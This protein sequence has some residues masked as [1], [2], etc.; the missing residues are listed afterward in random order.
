MVGKLLGSSLFGFALD[1]YFSSTLTKVSPWF[2]GMKQAPQI[3]SKKLAEAKMRNMYPI[4]RLA[5]RVG[6]ILTTAALMHMVRAKVT[7][8]ASVRMSVGNS[9]ALNSFRFRH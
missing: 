5:L 7:P 6:K 2:S 3:A 9:S 8:V 1:P 4:P